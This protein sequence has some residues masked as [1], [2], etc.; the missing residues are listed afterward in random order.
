VPWN[1]TALQALLPNICF[2]GCQV[3]VKDNNQETKEEFL[4][5]QLYTFSCKFLQS[6]SFPLA[7]VSK[8]C[9]FSSSFLKESSLSLPSCLALSS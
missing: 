6:C 7:L 8:F 2:K 9:K 4:P 3:Q 5:H 1:L